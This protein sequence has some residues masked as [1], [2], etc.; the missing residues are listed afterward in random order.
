MTKCRFAHGFR[1]DPMPSLKEAIPLMRRWRA[2]SASPLRSLGMRRSLTS[3]LEPYFPNSNRMGHSAITN[4]TLCQAPGRTAR[5]LRT[6]GH[7]YRFPSS[8][9]GSAFRLR[10]RRIRYDF[11]SSLR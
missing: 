6:N 3:E 10:N 9:M 8:A 11:L 1:N 7:T 5:Q 2:S 4:C